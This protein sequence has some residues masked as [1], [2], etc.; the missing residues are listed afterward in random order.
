MAY[1][2]LALAILAEVVGTSA[3]KAAEG[4]ARPLPTLI[5]ALGYGAAFYFMSLT[6]KTI[7]LGV[8]YAVWSGVGIVLITLAGWRLYGQA[9]DAAAVAGMALIVL[10][11]VVIF[12]FSRTVPHA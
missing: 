7:P 12:A 10:G 3:L 4:F 9:P 6:L 2:Y 11:V 1:L 5:V 8:T